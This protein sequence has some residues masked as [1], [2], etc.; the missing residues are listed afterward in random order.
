[1]SRLVSAIAKDTSVVKRAE[2]RVATGRKATLRDGAETRPATDNRWLQ[3]F[4]VRMR[5]Y[6]GALPSL[7]R[8][9]HSLPAKTSESGAARGSGGRN[10]R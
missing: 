10:R 2:L 9:N 7:S 4:V 3:I 1:M 6:C 8:E 5:G